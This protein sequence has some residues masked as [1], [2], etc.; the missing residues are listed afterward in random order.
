MA[1]FSVNQVRQFY[2][3]KETTDVTPKFCEDDKVLYFTVKDATGKDKHTD[4][5]NIDKIEWIHFTEAA[6][7]EPK[8]KK[9]IVT[10]NDD[11]LVDDKIIPG[12]D[13]I[14]RINLRQYIGMS[15]EDIYQKYGAV[16]GVKNMDVEAFLN[17]MKESLEK[18]FGR[19]ENATLTFEVDDVTVTVDGQ[20]VSK[21]ALIITEASPVG[22]WSRGT[23]PI[24]RVLFDVIPT[25][26][27]EP[28]YYNEVVWGTVETGE[29]DETIPNCYTLADMEWF[30][31]GYRGDQYRY[32]GWPNAIHTEY[33]VE[34]GSD[35]HYDVI[36]IQ[37]YYS[38]DNEDIQHSAK[39]MTFVGTETAIAAILTALKENEA[40]EAKIKEVKAAAEEQGGGN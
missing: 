13:Y 19:E 33:Q 12:Q 3:A 18:N 9:V 30:Y 14:L 7:M 1:V 16:H 29:A 15:D 36:D 5:I 17:K 32:K 20:E 21:K 8:L 10:V 31:H 24:K 39:T 38:G 23:C 4:H 22:E 11:A 25:T 35:V 27:T 2:V 40:V 34:V 37:Y 6:K 26:V 28:D